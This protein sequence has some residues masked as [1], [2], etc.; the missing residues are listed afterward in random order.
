MRALALFCLALLALGCGGGGGGGNSGG[1]LKT[2]VGTWSGTWNLSP[3]ENGTTTLV[4]E[5]QAG[6]PPYAINNAVLTNTINPPS[7]T[8]VCGFS[9][10]G[11]PSSGFYKHG[12]DPNLV[13][14]GG[15]LVLSQDGDTITG[16]VQIDGGLSVQLELMRQ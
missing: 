13:V 16:S 7:S 8:L 11:V 1:N 12:A 2:F 3:G 9:S 15:Q 14:I 4:I 10:A 6:P 5:S